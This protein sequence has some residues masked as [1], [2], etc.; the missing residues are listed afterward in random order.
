MNWKKLLKSKTVWAGLIA[1]ATII[2]EAP[3]V[4][5]VVV[6]KAASVFLG[7]VGVKDAI[8]RVGN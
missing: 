4:T 1:A 6:V 8:S 5:A 2:V 3:V 7:A